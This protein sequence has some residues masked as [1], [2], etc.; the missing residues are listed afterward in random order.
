MTKLI[1]M[2]D[3]T[4][5]EP[6]GDQPQQERR[7]VPFQPHSLEECITNV[8]TPTGK[9]K[10]LK[11]MV[12]TACERNCFYCPFRAGRSSMKR[13]T[14]SP[15]ELANGLDTLQQ[16]GKVE[17]MFLSSGIIKGSVKTQDKIIDTAE[18][19]RNRY[20]YHGYLHLKIMPGIEH[21]QLYRIMQLADRVSVNLEGPTQERLDALAPK[22]DF[23][24]ELL[25]M[26]QLAEQIR[27][28]HPYEKLAS[29]VTQF[30]VGAVGDTDLELLS[31]SHRLYRH[32]GLTRAY[33]SGFSPVIQT[34]FENLPATDPLREHRLYQASF[35]LR[36][37]GWK[38][39][40]LPFLSDG[41]MLLDMDPKRA[42]AEQHLR[43]T[44][45]ELMKA[46]RQQLLRIPGIGPI[47]ADAVLRARRLGRLTEL[48]HLRQLN[49]RAP[50]QAAP[51]I[52]LDGHR[53]VIQMNLF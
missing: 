24:R 26:L 35:L 48:S 25:S 3:A 18:I 13:L 45:I 40:D 12:T 22:K 17:G 19:M 44:P 41:N 31:L 39:E 20:D 28:T 33:Y 14:F 30:V 37:Y 51:Y 6:V 52:L 21:E 50:E 15:D 8:S 1:Q 42:W 2:G 34:P 4:A 11:A 10:I 5:Y 53:P 36:D 29:T 38:V 23:Q 47:G 7:R 46:S 27:R 16:A 49:I 32:Y 43:E 9:R